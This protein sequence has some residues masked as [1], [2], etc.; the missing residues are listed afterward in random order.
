MKLK[1]KVKREYAQFIE[2][3]GHT[4]KY[5]EVKLLYKGDAVMSDAQLDYVALGDT[6][7]GDKN[8]D[9]VSFAF[10]TI[11]A[12]TD[13]IADI[14]TPFGEYLSAGYYSPQEKEFQVGSEDF[15]IVEFHGFFD[16]F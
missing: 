8:D 15:T 14:D 12:L 4:P 1:D 5:A 11:D 9:K 16:E 7:D 3:N 2:E 13:T 10:H 6:T